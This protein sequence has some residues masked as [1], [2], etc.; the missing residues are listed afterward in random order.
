MLRSRLFAL[1]ISLLISTLLW[2]LIKLSAEITETQT[3]PL[4]V[5]VA[6]NGKILSLA[7]PET[8]T[9][10]YKKQ[11]F[12]MSVADIFKKKKPV[13][14]RL[15][16]R[17]N[18]IGSNGRYT[19]TINMKEYLRDLEDSLET[20]NR[21][22]SVK[23]D[24]LKLFLEDVYIKK[25][26]VHLNLS[27]SFAR[28]YEL[29]S[30]FYYKPD[31]VTVRGLK[32]DVENIFRLETQAKALNEI[33]STHYFSLGIV[34][35]SEKRNLKIIPGEVTVCIP[36]EKFTEGSILVS[37]SVLN[38]SARRNIRLF[39]DR[40]KIVYRVSMKDYSKVNPRMFE[41]SIDFGSLKHTEN[42]KTKI[43]LMN[44]PDFVRITKITPEKAEYFIY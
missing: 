11:G 43:H 22:I 25:V 33:S 27:V 9:I 14:V 10:T 3:Y 1:I 41:A 32:K 42:N 12:S 19:A 26:P 4:I 23:P 29:Y 31:S 8:V 17:M 16:G 7:P 13:V 20:F 37:I 15:T 34:K 6:N 21:V 38:N 40:V 5:K 18:L 44:Y 36:V 30:P 35:P 39:P 24:S 2:I 28:Q